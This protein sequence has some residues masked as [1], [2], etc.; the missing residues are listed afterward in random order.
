MP[1]LYVMIKN[2]LTSIVLIGLALIVGFGCSKSNEKTK[3]ISNGSIQK[4][5]YLALFNS[6]ETSQVVTISADDWGL[7][8]VVVP[9]SEKTTSLVYQNVTGHAPSFVLQFEFHK[10]EKI[11]LSWREGSSYGVSNVDGGLGVPGPAAKKGVMS[12]CLQLT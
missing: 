3:E 9:P 1:V 2:Q 6:H 12:L 7:W 4:E 8:E 5:N 10:F 11:M